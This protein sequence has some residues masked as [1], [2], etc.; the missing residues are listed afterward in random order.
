MRVCTIIHFYC[1]ED[2]ISKIF[3]LFFLNRFVCYVK[4]GSL[5]IFNE[6]VYFYFCFFSPKNFEFDGQK[7]LKNAKMFSNREKKASFV[8]IALLEI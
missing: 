3:I 7:V 6:I 1:F 2:Y 5:G 4:T 8:N